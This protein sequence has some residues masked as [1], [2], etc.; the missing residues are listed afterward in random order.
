MCIYINS[1]CCT[2]LNIYKVISNTSIN[3]GWG[4]G[5]Y[6]R[7]PWLHNSWKRVLSIW[8]KTRE[9]SWWPTVSLRSSVSSSRRLQL[10]RHSGE[11]QKLSNQEALLCRRGT[12]S[13]PDWVGYIVLLLISSVIFG[14][15]L[16]PWIPKLPSVRHC[17]LYFFQNVMVMNRYAAYS[18][19]KTFKITHVKYL[20]SVLFRETLCRSGCSIKRKNS[21]V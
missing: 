5:L 2:A 10:A 13:Q 21:D 3:L 19:T 11:F 9:C 12:Q 8:N 18:Y 20:W 14:L 16:T 17:Y 1:S 6:V 15:R 7:R 4:W